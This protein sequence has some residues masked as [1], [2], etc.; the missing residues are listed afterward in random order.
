MRRRP[1]FAPVIV[2]AVLVAFGGIFL[3]LQGCGAATTPGGLTSHSWT[4]TR[5]VVDGKEQPLA[6]GRSLTLRFQERDHTVSGF[7]GC[8]S[9]GGSYTIS[10]DS[11][12]FDHMQTTV[13]ACAN[14]DVM[15]LEAAYMRAL[16]GVESYHLDGAT[17]S[18]SGDSGHVQMSFQQGDSAA[19]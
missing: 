1:V 14:A 12:R 15:G 9:Y 13:M 19:P 11:L 8:N 4:L 6:Q 7:S 3:A 18:L 17:L 5:L 2:A 16:D 10:G